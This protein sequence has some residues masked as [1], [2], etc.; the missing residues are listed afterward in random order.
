MCPSIWFLHTPGGIVLA[1]MQIERA[2]E[3]HPAKVTVYVPTYAMSGGTL[4]ALAADENRHRIH[5]PLEC[6]QEHRQNDGCRC[7]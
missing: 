3:A 5:R 7:E 6:R 1:A 4:I 2:A